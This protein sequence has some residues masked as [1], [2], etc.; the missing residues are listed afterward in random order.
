MRKKHSSYTLAN[1]CHVDEITR[2]F[3]ERKFV[4]VWICRENKDIKF[5][6]ERRNNIIIIF[7]A[8]LKKYR[9]SE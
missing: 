7:Y 8:Y 4:K 1:V 6:K 2:F 5:K 3:N 9:Q